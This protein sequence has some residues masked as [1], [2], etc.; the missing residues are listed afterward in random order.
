M[1]HHSTYRRIAA[2][3]VDVEELEQ[4]VHRWFGS[5]VDPKQQIWISMDGKVLRGT[6]DERQKGTYLL[7]AYLPSQGLVLM[8]IAIA[9]KGS[10]NPGAVELLHHIDLRSSVVIGDAL[11]TQREI[12]PIQ[13]LIRTRSYWG[14][15]NGLHYRRDVTLL[16]DRTRMSKGHAGR[17]MACLNNILLGLLAGY[18][19][20]RFLPAIHRYFDAH[21]DQAFALIA[22]L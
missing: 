13:L 18:R 3:V 20:Q 14:I 4:M 6:L 21:P 9:G 7:A 5:R 8:E 1:P 11:H 10:E 19:K 22:G 2:E 17:V 16:E 12:S 15:E